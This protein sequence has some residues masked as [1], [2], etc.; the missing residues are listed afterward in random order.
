MVHVDAAARS[1][2]RGWCGHDDGRSTSYDAPMA[3]P[4]R[5]A[6]FGFDQIEASDALKLWPIYLVVTLCD[7]V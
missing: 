5:L 1:A 3:G 7:D 4:R 6:F 2:R